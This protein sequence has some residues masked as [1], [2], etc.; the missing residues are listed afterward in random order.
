MNTEPKWVNELRQLPFKPGKVELALTTY[1]QMASPFYK[2]K[3]LDD[4]ER[5]I[6]TWIL[7]ADVYKNDKEAGFTKKER[8]F[9]NWAN[10]IK[11]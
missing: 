4:L 3:S 11:S 1:D 8:D 9:Y 10:A 2:Q 6:I 7:R 5:V